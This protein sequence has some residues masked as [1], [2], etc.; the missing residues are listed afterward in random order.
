MRARRYAEA[1]T[2]DERVLA[3]IELHDMPYAVWRWK[4]GGGWRKRRALDRLAAAIPDKEL[5]LR[6]VELD[7]STEGKKP[8][9]IDWIRRE[10]G[11]RSGSA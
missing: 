7:G 5:F 10:L 3:T 2:T 1:W 11:R 4:L 9:P 6:F 8:E